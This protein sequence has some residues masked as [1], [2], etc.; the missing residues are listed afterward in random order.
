MKIKC[1]DWVKKIAIYK[2]R[3]AVQLPDKIIVYE[4]Y[5]DDVSDMHY[6][7]KDKVRHALSSQGQGMIIR[8]LFRFLTSVEKLIQSNG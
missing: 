5:S 8:F 4:L 6:R 2:Y 1:R 7:V 3:L